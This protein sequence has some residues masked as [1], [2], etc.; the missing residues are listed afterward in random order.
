MTWVAWRQHRWVFAGIAA[1]FA[2]LSALFLIAEASGNGSVLTWSG[3]V[4]GGFPGFLRSYE[5]LNNGFAPL[6]ILVGMLAGAPLLAGELEHG[7]HR[8]SWTQG[9]SRNRWLVTKTLMIGAVVTVF[10]AAYASVHTRWYQPYAAQGGWFMIAS[11]GSLAL[12]A[13]CLF[14]FALGTAAGALLGRVV[15]AMAT[16]VVGHLAVLV[17]E[18]AFVRRNHLLGEAPDFWTYQAI[19]LGL[20][21]GLAACCL[22]VSFLAVRNKFS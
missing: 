17:V 7:T 15:P 1:M 12:P 13:A 2:V 8:Y 6:P 14:T 11:Q 21:A 18:R 20:Y 5:E 22:A 19:Q 4:I 10:S 9:V 16:V 3:T